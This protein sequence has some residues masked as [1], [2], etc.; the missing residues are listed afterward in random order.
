ME[1]F[2]H[3]FNMRQQPGKELMLGFFGN[4]DYEFDTTTYEDTAK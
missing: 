4:A 1:T 3:F 2:W